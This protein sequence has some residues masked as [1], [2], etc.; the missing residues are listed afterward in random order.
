M[1]P[2]NDGISYTYLLSSGKF[3]IL[4]QNFQKKVEGIWNLTKPQEDEEF[5]KSA[6]ALEPVAST[7][8]GG[9]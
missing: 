9:T 1:N 7:A 6:A 3:N 5:V 2:D 4:I 8:E